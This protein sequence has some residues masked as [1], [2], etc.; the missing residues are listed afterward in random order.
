MTFKF[1][2]RVDPVGMTIPYA[3]P[4]RRRCDRRWGA[5]SSRNLEG[6]AVAALRITLIANALL[7]AEIDRTVEN[8]SQE[9]ALAE[10]IG[11]ITVEPEPAE[12]LVGAPGL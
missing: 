6:D 11:C 1:T 5:R 3:D 8:A 12:R 9:A 7:K 2:F 4:A 10:M